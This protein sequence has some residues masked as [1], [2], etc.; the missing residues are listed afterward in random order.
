VGVVDRWPA[1]LGEVPV[2]TPHEPLDVRPDEAILGNVPAAGYRDLHEHDF[3]HQIG[4]TFQEGLQC[5]HPEIDALGVIETIDTEDHHF[6]VSE[7]RPDPR[8]S[9]PSIGPRQT[10]EAA[11]A[12]ADRGVWSVMSSTAI[13]AS[14]TDR[15]SG[16]GRAARWC[17]STWTEGGTSAPKAL[18]LGDAG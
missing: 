16:G 7:S 8:A 14:R 15:C 1:D 6:G 11:G 18:E 9:F 3:P 13:R 10:V 5:A 17:D 12:D 4:A 2:D